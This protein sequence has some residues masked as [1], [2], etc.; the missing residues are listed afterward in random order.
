VDFSPWIG[1][2]EENRAWDLL[3][4]ARRSV[5]DY[6]N[7][8]SANLKSLDLA[9][10]TIYSAEN[11]TFF[12]HFGAEKDGGIPRRDVHREFTATLAQVYSILGPYRC[13]RKFG[14][15][16]PGKGARFPG[17]RSLGRF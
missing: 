6:Q 4:I 1:D 15:G 16:F 11:G 5:N 12:D 2:E 9:K 14:R 13:R 7:S 3:G 8:G 17:G 10:R